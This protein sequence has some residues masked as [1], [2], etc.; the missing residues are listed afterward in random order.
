MYAPQSAPRDA[1]FIQCTENGTPRRL[2]CPV[3]ELRPHPSYVRHGLSVD[4]SRLSALAQR[5]DLAFRDPIVITRERF[6]VDGY[7]RW[8]LAKRSGRKAIE[9]FEHDL[10]PE[11]ALEELI[12]THHRSDGF[13]DFRRI[14]LALDLESHFQQRAL[15][16]QQAGG[17][18]KGL[19]TLTTAQRVDTR[20]EVAQLAGVSCGNV[21]KVKNI[22]LHACPSLLEAARSKEV[23]I[24]LADKW[25]DQPPA[26][27]HEYLRRFRIERGIRKKARTLVAAHCAQLMRSDRD[28]KAFKLLDVVDGLNQLVTSASEQSR[29]VN[30]I[31]VQIIK[32]SGRRIFVTEELACSLIATQRVVG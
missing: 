10:S 31:E 30:S 25:S 12:R 7:A 32:A 5:G 2:W 29:D 26:Q 1:E 22:L 24:N 11:D 17:R 6:V 16:N 18:G 13:I 4:T 23:S 20:R 27:Q 8:E 9:C 15:R 3:D 14:E 28:D 19:S 21:R